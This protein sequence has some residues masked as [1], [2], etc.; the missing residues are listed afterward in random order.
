M[1]WGQ[2]FLP[3]DVKEFDYA[4]FW[5]FAWIPLWDNVNY[6]WVW[7]ERVAIMHYWS[8]SE[9]AWRECWNGYDTTFHRCVFDCR[10]EQAGA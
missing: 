5:R 1:R 3:K 10:T 6:C 8:K 2:R 9:L 4:F 7:W